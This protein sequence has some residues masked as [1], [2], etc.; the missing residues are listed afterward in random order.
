VPVI[1]T[2]IQYDARRDLAQPPTDVPVFGRVLSPPVKFNRTTRA[3]FAVVLVAL[4]AAVAGCGSEG[5]SVPNSQPVAQKGATIFA[6]RCG[7]CHTIS[8]AGTQGSKP[9]GET[10]S[11]DR[12]NGPN[13]NSRQETYESVITAIRQGGFSG[14]IMPGNI[15]TGK[16]AD[17]VAVFLAKYSGK[18][19][20]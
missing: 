2:G 13:F 8:A 6:E 9:K 20:N 1:A 12:T 4:S 7:G 18:D 5:N 15:V 11:Q 16:E 14:A 10:N 19:P 17:A 3:V